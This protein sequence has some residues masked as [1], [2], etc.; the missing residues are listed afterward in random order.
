MAA[1]VMLMKLTDKGLADLK[2]A[3]ARI[4]DGIKVLEAAGGAMYSFHVT[5]GAYDYVA[6]GE[7]PDDDAAA[8]VAL[9]LAAGGNVTTTTLRAFTRQEFASLVAKLP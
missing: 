8:L 6:V 4:E 9:S 2:N 7:A 1:F 3:P 5:M